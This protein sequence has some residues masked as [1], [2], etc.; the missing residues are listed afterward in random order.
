[1]PLGRTVLPLHAELPRRLATGFS[2]TTAVVG[3]AGPGITS[4]PCLCDLPYG[5]V[6]M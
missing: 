5:H 1:L 4:A 2:D 6:P 3:E